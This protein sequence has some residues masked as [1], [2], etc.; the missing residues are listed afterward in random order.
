ML[1]QQSCCRLAHLYLGRDS[2]PFCTPLMV[3]KPRYAR[4]KWGTNHNAPGQVFA[5]PSSSHVSQNNY[6]EHS[7]GI[8]WQS[9]QRQQAAAK[10][11][12]LEHTRR[13][14]ENVIS[15]YRQV[16]VHLWLHMLCQVDWCLKSTSCHLC[17][18]LHHLLLAIYCQPHLHFVTTVS[19]LC[20]EDRMHPTWQACS[21]RNCLPYCLLV[22]MH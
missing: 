6:F 5:Y 7:H 1:T 4:Y 17:T 9:L 14:L 22:N 13:V 3:H 20:F 2:L 16:S 11:E 12:L 8:E 15:Q 18:A 19:F 21:S 10:E